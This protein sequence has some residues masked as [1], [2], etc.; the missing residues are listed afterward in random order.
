MPWGLRRRG[1]SVAFMARDRLG[2]LTL[3]AAYTILAA[4]HEAGTVVP[5]RALPAAL[6]SAQDLL[7]AAL[8]LARPSVRTVSRQWSDRLVA[9]AALLV[10]FGLHAPGA[11]VTSFSAALEV[12]GL[13]LALL[14]TAT[15]GRHCGVLPAVRGLT[16]RGV[17]A[18]VRHPMYAAYM[19]LFIAYV[20][21]EPSAHNATFAVA[22]CALLVVRLR[23]EEAI[24]G[25]HV[26]Y[27][28]YRQR[29]PWRLVPGCY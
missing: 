1:T 22:A 11:A 10:P 21:G 3:A 24:L 28:E 5:G 4:C 26:D 25:R 20:A 7:V 13:L 16:T 14:A 17:Y 29:V 9:A 12:A 27:Q 6:L 8:L 18:V 19:L 23:T 15:L 2:A